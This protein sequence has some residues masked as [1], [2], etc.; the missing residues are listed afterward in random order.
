MGQRWSLIEAHLFSCVMGREEHCKQI[1][2]ACVGSARS[3]WTT[4]GLPQLTVACA[5]QVYTAQAP[6]CSA[7]LLSK[8][9]P[10]FHAL[11]RS[12]LLRFQFLGNRKGTDSVGHVFVPF[13]GLC[14]SGDQVLG[15]STVPGGPCILITSPVPAAQ[16]PRCARRA[17]SQ[18]CCVSPLGSWSQAV[19]LLADVNRPGSQEDVISNWE[20]AHGLVEDAG[21]WGWD[22]PLPSGSGCRTQASASSRGEGPVHCG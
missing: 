18:V 22:C 4:L 21:L 3:V 20:P 8:V 5:F 12:K 17:P 15:E 7:G 14:S 16:F 1:S 19:T 2:L 6:G 13:P 11:S 9:D 10:A